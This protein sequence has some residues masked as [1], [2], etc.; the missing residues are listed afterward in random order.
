MKELRNS[1]SKIK[2]KHGLRKFKKITDEI[3]EAKIANKKADRYHQK[4]L[5]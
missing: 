4:Y 5:Y 3:A 2:A 1:L